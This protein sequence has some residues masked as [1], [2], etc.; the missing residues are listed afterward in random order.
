MFG[1][2]MIVP[3]P[4]AAGRRAANADNF[5]ESNTEEGGS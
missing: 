5:E 1:E 2:I 4:D 3:A